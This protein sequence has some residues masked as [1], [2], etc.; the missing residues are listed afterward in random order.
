MAEDLEK[1][2]QKIA[3]AARRGVQV[4]RMWHAKLEA[5]QKQKQATNPT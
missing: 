3:E 5:D 1:L 4:E 2:A